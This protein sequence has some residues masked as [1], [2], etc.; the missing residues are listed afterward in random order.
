MSTQAIVLKPPAAP[1]TLIPRIERDSRIIAF[2]QTIPGKLAILACA[3]AI[4]GLRGVLQPGV[5]IILAGI[6]LLPEYRWLLMTVG[7]LCWIPSIV[8]WSAG[9]NLDIFTRAACVGLVLV[10]A[11][12]LVGITRRWPRGLVAKN[13]RITLL[14]IFAATVTTAILLPEGQARVASWAFVASLS[15]ALWC[16]SFLFREPPWATRSAWHGV[17]HFSPYGRWGFASSTPFLRRPSQMRRMEAKTAE[18]FAIIQLKGLKLLAWSFLL[19]IAFA[20][21]DTVREKVGIPVLPDAIAA[22]TAGHSYPWYVCWASLLA[23]FVDSVLR[24]A[25]W[26]N[27]VVAG[28]RLAGFRLLRNTYRPLQSRTVVDFWN[29]Y[30]YY[31]KELIADFFFFPVYTRC[32]KTHPRV[33]LL[34]ATW[35]SVG[36]GIPLF[37]FIRDIHYVAELGFVRA[38]TGFHVYLCYATMLAIGIG[39]SQIRKTTA[40]TRTKSASASRFQL[41]SLAG[42]ILFFCFLQ[43]FDETRRTVPIHE[44]LLFLTRLAGRTN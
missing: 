2:A 1:Q 44:H 32:F 9:A 35:V 29:R 13:P 7:G 38:V 24:M 20:I 26:G 17:R 3:A 5:I 10:L 33:R 27:T 11:I 22:S 42:V 43:V 23:G 39:I 41:R 18:D 21:F 37:H 16:V 36:L 6:S 15:A 28:C 40:R 34:F 14:A 30:Y 19:A 31:F 4:F 12:L 25:V 8:E